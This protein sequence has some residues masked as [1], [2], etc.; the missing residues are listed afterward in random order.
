MLQCSQT[1]TSQKVIS[2]KEDHSYQE[3]ASSEESKSM[4]RVG[5]VCIQVLTSEYNNYLVSFSTCSPLS[6]LMPFYLQEKARQAESDQIT[7]ELFDD[8]NKYFDLSPTPS[9]LSDP[10]P[11]TSPSSNDHSSSS[12]TS[13]AY[14]PVYSAVANMNLSSAS[15]TPPGY[16]STYSSSSAGNNLPSLYCAV[17]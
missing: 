4:F 14:P 15:I 8:N 6:C 12:V 1:Q 5:S 10:P 16:R 3:A 13:P 9:P 7:S 17:L 11:L 2:Q